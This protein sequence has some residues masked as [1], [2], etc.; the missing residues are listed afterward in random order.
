[1]TQ[2]H[3][4]NFGILGT[5]LVILWL[6]SPLGSQASLRAPSIGT[7]SVSSRVDLPYLSMENKNILSGRDNSDR[8]ALRV[9]M[10][11]VVISSL[12]SDPTVKQ[13][14]R[15]TWGNL[16]IPFLDSSTGSNDDQH[17][18]W[19]TVDWGDYHI[20]CSLVGIP[21]GNIPSEGKKSFNLDSSY[22]KLDCPI[23]TSCV[24]LDEPN[25]KEIDASLGANRRINATGHILAVSYDDDMESKS[26]RTDLYMPPRK[27][28][29]MFEGSKETVL[30]LCDMTID[31]VE[32]QVSCLGRDCGVT[33]MRNS[34]K[35]H[36]PKASTYFD[37]NPVVMNEF[38]SEFVWMIEGRSARNSP[39]TTF[40]TDPG[41]PF[42]VNYTAESISKTTTHAS[43]SRSLSQLI[44]TCWI[45]SIGSEI[46]VQGEK[47]TPLKYP[48]T[49]FERTEANIETEEKILVCNTG[50]FTALLLATLPPLLAG[51]ISVH[52]DVIP[53]S[54]GPCL[55]MNITTM[56][57]DNPY[58]D[59]PAGGSTLD[60]SE[61]SKLLQNVRV[62]LGDV[63]PAAKT[64]HIALGTISDG[65]EDNEQGATVMRLQRERLYD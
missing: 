51:I 24:Y 34:T 25:C 10:T 36:P 38:M 13:S 30:S 35:A 45:A 49:Q 55:S 59:I 63:A 47:A 26:N 40:F 15:D 56:I 60:D 53:S 7:F 39:L 14:P 9:P 61:R 21:V 20:S 28:L 41:F 37:G 54:L 43:F 11:A 12:L 8:V 27:F 33:R 57:R 17:S 62:R 23:R 5:S 65:N 1:M 16:K 42:N 58:V 4:Q 18:N 48:D 29:F 2:V 3:L 52:F 46:L 64:G 50:W 22:F 6:L 32:M 31:H 44:N 19:S